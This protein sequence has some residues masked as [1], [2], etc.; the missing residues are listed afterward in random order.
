MPGFRDLARNQDHNI[1]VAAKGFGVGS[2]R[3]VAVNALKGRT[4]GC[5]GSEYP[6]GEKLYELAQMGSEIEVDTA[7]PVIR[8]GGGQFRFELSAME[9]QLIQVGGVK[10]A[11]E[12]FGKDLFNQLCRP[13][14]AKSREIATGRGVGAVADIEVLPF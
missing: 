7:A 9:K 14:E 10:G 1:I 6:G 4:S 11:F 3:E 8:C 13:Q 2:S 5:S 12:R